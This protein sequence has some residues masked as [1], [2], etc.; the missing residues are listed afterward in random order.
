MTTGILSGPERPDIINRASAYA[1][2]A[3]R[4]IAVLYFLTASRQLHANQV[5]NGCEL[6]P[7]SKDMESSRDMEP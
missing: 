6:A 1:P 7:R 4:H 3:F 2:T 5:H